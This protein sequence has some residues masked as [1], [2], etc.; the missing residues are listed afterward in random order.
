LIVHVPSHAR[1]RQK[2]VTVITFASV[3]NDVL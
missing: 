1:H 3:S 2:L